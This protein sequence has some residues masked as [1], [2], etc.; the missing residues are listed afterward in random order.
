MGMFIQDKAVYTTGQIAAMLKM[1][2]RTVSGLIDSGILP[3][4]R[5]PNVKD[6]TKLGDRRVYREDLIAFI[7]KQ[8]GMRLPAELSDARSLLHVW[9][10]SPL[11][12]NVRLGLDKLG[13]D[14]TAR[15]SVSL[16]DATASATL[17]LPEAIIIDLSVGR[18]DS[19]SMLQ[20]VRTSHPGKP[21]CAIAIASEDDAD[22]EGLKQKGFHAVFKKP[23]DPDKIAAEI[24]DAIADFWAKDKTRRPR[25]VC[26]GRKGTV[27]VAK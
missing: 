7:Q 4:Y 20:A 27:P 18:S 25:Y 10:D 14:W 19:I 17:S 8:P 24:V 16:F 9:V 13:G 23:L 15:E 3:G 21:F 5:I 11:I 22:Q 6:P 12:D 26:A 1:V 2:P